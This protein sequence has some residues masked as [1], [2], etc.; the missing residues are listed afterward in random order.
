MS[1]NFSEFKR[2]LGAEPRSGDPE[3]LRARQSAPEFEQAAA[4]AERFEEKLQRAFNIPVPKDLSERL[5]DITE[6]MPR[7][8]QRRWLPVALAASVLVAVAAAFINWNMN[9]NWDSVEAYVSDHYRH[10][11][12]QMIAL[13]EGQVA[14]GVGEIFSRFEV[15]ALPEL[16]NA[17]NVIKYCPTPDGKGVHMVVDAGEGPVTVIYMPE[18]RVTHGESLPIDDVEAVLV[19]LQKG[20]A[21]IIGA[22]TEGLNRLYALVQS[23]IVPA[24]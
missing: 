20:S 2:I 1:M 3:F 7:T 22:S 23:S 13:A 16:A 15:Q 18:T 8:Q 4:E 21:A 17:I 14:E 12:P 6:F 19:E 5:S 9:P 11:G 24:G 10:D